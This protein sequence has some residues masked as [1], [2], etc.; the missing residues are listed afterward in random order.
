VNWLQYAAVTAGFGALYFHFDAGHKMQEHKYCEALVAPA[1][2][3]VLVVVVAL[4]AE[5]AVIGLH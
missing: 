1:S 4:V 2:V 5:I 3:V